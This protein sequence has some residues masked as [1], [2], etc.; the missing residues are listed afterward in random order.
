[1]TTG[2]LKVSLRRHGP[3]VPFVTAGL[4]GVFSHGRAPS[5]TLKGS[6]SA[7]FV[8]QGQGGILVR[9]DESDSVTVRLVQPNRAL[10]GV[11][12]GGF[13]HELSHVTASASTSGCTSGQTWSTP[14]S[15][16]VRP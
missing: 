8:F 2:T 5:V 16:P 7:G 3:F 6:Y 11:V 1:M 4:G 14:R 9:F 13:T 10:V 15:A 12:G